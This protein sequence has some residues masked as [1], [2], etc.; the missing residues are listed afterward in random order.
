MPTPPTVTVVTRTRN[1]PLLLDRAVRAAMQQ[2]L[3]DLHM[4][5]VNDGGDPA[6][7]ED[8]IA[9]RRDVARERVTVIHHRES[10]GM[11]AA[12]NAGIRGSS[13]RY[14]AILDDDD[15]W[16]PRFLELAVG[17]AEQSG[18]MGTVTNTRVVLESTEYG[19]VRLSQWFDFDPLAG[20]WMP[21]R[22]PT[23]LFRLISW[24]QFPPC[25]F[26][27]RRDALDDVGEYDESLP[28]L[29][30]WDFNI[31]FLLRHRVGHLPLPLA[32]YHHRTDSSAGLG[33]SVHA[34][35]DLHERVRLEL[36]ERYLRRDLEQGKL[37]VGFLS[38]LLYDLRQAR[39]AEGTAQEE[40]A[41]RLDRIDDSLK[42]IA[43]RLDRIA[44]DPGGDPVG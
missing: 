41:R 38:N 22:P 40:L 10:L 31:R 43:D 32:Y 33:N 28:V 7:V 11:E 15:S 25:A 17:A 42:Q 14:V 23:D 30:D 12:S 29:G 21:Y 1:R 8:V 39:S 19:D 6:Q 2:T 9:A 3:T 16:H 20:A 36:L 4:V 26:V 34:G 35:E 13:S 44:S 24:N 18:S 5:I 37:G 27:Y